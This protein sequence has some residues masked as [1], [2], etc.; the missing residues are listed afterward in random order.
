MVDYFDI[1]WQFIDDFQCFCGLFHAQR[2]HAEF[3]GF[4][5]NFP[6]SRYD[7]F[8]ILFQQEVSLATEAFRGCF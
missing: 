1:Q 2:N 7:M 6:A 4:Y 3:T 8:L 5:L